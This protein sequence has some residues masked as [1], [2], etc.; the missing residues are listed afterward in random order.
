MAGV[1]AMH[2]HFLL[3]DEPTAGLDIPGQEFVFKLVLDLAA[4]GVGV[5]VVSH[6]VESFSQLA[7]QVYVLEHGKLVTSGPGEVR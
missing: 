7:D 2:P 3:L 1:L 6:D 5:L 4:R